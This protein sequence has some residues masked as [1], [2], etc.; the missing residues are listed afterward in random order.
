MNGWRQLNSVLRGLDSLLRLAER[1][2]R[3]RR[4][5]DSEPLERR[6]LREAAV[7]LEEVEGVW[8]ERKVADERSKES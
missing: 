4:E 1:G 7:D 8:Q 3:L 6:K 5:P 2:E